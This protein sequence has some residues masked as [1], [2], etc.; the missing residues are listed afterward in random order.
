MDSTSHLPSAIGASPAMAQWFAVKAQHPDALVFFRMGDFYELFFSDAEAAA[1]A[2]DIALTSRGEH[3]GA[4]IAMCGV[5]V[6]AAEAYLA[7]LI[8]RGFRVAVAEQMED[9]KVR[10]SAKVPI[11]RDVVRL[12]TPGT[13]TEDSLLEA[14]RANYL[15]ALA[16]GHAALGAAW[17]DMSTGLFETAALAP[18]DLPALLGRLDPAEIL[19]PAMVDLGDWTVRRGPEGSPSAPQAARRKLADAFAVASLEAFGHFSDAETAAAAM[20]LDY[21]RA[22]QAGNLPRLS[23]PMP[24][25]RDGSLAMDAATRASLEILRARDGG[26]THTL[27]GAVQR[28]LS[29]AGARLLAEHLAAPLTDPAG[30]AARQDGWSWLL[31][32]LDAARD[33]RVALRAAPDMARALGRISL[34][35]GGPRDLAAIRDGLAAGMAARAALVGQLP[36]VLN[37]CA[38][39]LAVDP[40]LEASLRAALA[41][42]APLRL[43]DGGAVRPGYDGELDG[44][45]ALRDDTRGTLAKL[46]LDYAQR[47]GVAA[48]KIKYHAQLGYVIEVPAVAVEKLQAQPDLTLRQGMAN[49]ARFSNPELAELNQRIVQAVDRAAARERVV[50]AHL[51]REALAHADALAAC[52]SALARLDVAQSAAR[53]AESGKW[54]RPLISDDDAFTITAGRHPVVEA[55]LAGPGGGHAVFV[56]NHCDLSP[57]R[58]LLLLTG[59]NMAGKSTFIRQNALAVIM[60]QAGQPVAAEAARIGVVD[61]LFSRV[62]GADDLARGRSTFMV[63]MTETAAILHQAGPKSLVVVDEIGRGTATLDGLAIA[64][65]VLEALHTANRCRAIFATHFHELGALTDRLPRLAPHTMRVKEWKGAVVFLHEV[66]EG[67]AGRS[68]GVHAAELAGVPAPVVRRAGQLLALLEKNAGPLGGRAVMTDALP[69]FAPAPTPLPPLPDAVP[70]PVHDALARLDLDAMSPREAQAFLYEIKRLIVVPTPDPA[71]PSL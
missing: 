65:A 68:W 61:R 59:P 49:G 66:A 6:H 60:A 50:F 14:G 1:A 40:A 37:V 12:I 30:I 9:P 36:H 33:L 8:R 41:D 11:R 54:C 25:G 63:E 29:A 18:G 48:L 69:L 7:R 20:A 16:P 19:A 5:P 38:V 51:L 17:L 2:L 67:A 32:N 44:E 70:D 57:E 3:A 55:A 39:A 46:Q 53:L 31:V 56:P 26:T 52:A 27:L 34:Q 71:L 42:P 58:R 62:G 24:G 21:V 4:R 28:T 10:R 23:Q 22:T 45:R 47:Y 15:L 35:R 64:W 13:L 43:D